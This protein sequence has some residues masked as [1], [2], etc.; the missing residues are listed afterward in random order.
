M[1]ATESPRYVERTNPRQRVTSWLL[2]AWKFGGRWEKGFVILV[3]IGIVNVI[4]V[5]FLSAWLSSRAGWPLAAMWSVLIAAFFFPPFQQAFIVPAFSPEVIRESLRR[6]LGEGEER[7]YE[8]L[9]EYKEKYGA[10]GQLPGDRAAGFLYWTIFHANLYGA[11]AITLLLSPVAGEWAVIAYAGIDI[12][13]ALGLRLLYL[14]RTRG[15][16]LE[17]K[18]RGFPLTDLRLESIRRRRK[19]HA[20]L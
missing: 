3:N 6:G 20:R 9:A 12:P 14:F 8:L 16:F 18:E 11:I 10:K 15:Q 5:A 1:T 17:A 2:L 13:I 7:Y 4:V 19:E